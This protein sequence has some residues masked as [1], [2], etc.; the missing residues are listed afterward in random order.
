LIE[1]K[2][3]SAATRTGMLTT[4]NREFPVLADA[5]NSGYSIGPFAARTKVLDGDVLEVLM[6]WTSLF[7]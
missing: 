4:G 3:N 1:G 6:R 7:P 5:R 2:D